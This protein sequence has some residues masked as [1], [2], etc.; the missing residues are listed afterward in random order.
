MLAL[1]N[2]ADL[3][4]DDDDK[5]AGCCDKAWELLTG[6]D[7]PEDTYT[8]F[9]YKKCAPAFRAHG[10]FLRAGELEKKADSIYDRA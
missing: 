3:Y 7:V 1:L 6:K 4:F 5:A 10:Y 2:L 9:I 8:A